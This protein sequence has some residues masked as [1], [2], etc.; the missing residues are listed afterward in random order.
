MKRRWLNQFLQTPQQ[1]IQD[2]LETIRQ[3]IGGTTIVSPPITTTPSMEQSSTED[4]PK[5][6]QQPIEKLFTGPLSVQDLKTPKWLGLE[7]NLLANGCLISSEVSTYE[8]DLTK[9]SEISR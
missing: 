4:S 3:A 7:F 5:K 6:T 8:F 9:V 1:D 2:D